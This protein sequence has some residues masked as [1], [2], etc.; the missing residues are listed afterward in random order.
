MQRKVCGQLLLA[1]QNRTVI[2]FPA[3]E[4]ECTVHAVLR[5][6]HTGRNV[7]DG[8]AAALNQRLLLPE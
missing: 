2:L 5:A 1:G 3:V 4:G 7:C 6:R 8:V